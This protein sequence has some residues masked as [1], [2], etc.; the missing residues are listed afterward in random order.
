VSKSR[1]KYRE[2]RCQGMEV[3][4]ELERGLV[5]VKRAT[6]GPR[7]TTYLVGLIHGRE[8][9]LQM[10]AKPV[11]FLPFSY[12]TNHNLSSRLHGYPR[13]NP[14]QRLHLFSQTHER[15]VC[16]S[17]CEHHS[18]LTA[19]TLS[20]FAL[21]APTLAGHTLPSH[22]ERPRLLSRPGPVFSVA[23]SLSMEILSHAV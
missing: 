5:V 4:V 15:G 14:P 2:Y 20:S 23:L 10:E 18:N 6:L 9:T 12:N 3:G 11:T 16:P 22:P 7:Q 8:L 19:L 17:A 21:T 1:G 13:N